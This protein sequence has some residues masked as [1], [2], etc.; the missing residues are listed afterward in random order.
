MQVGTG[1][2]WVMTTSNDGCVVIVDSEEKT[3]HTDV[4]ISPDCLNRNVEKGKF[5]KHEKLKHNGKPVYV[6]TSDLQ[7]FL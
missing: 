5:T 4:I 7:K 3:D 6:L 1:S 2:R